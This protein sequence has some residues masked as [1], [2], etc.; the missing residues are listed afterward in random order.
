MSYRLYVHF[1]VKN[2]NLLIPFT[3]IAVFPNIIKKKS[4]MQNNICNCSKNDVEKTTLIL[5]CTHAKCL[6]KGTEET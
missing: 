5:A 1:S 3:D 6:R 4:K 2:F